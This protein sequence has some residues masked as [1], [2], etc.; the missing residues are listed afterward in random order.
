[1][2]VAG[3]NIG[4]CVPGQRCFD[5]AFTQHSNSVQAEQAGTL[6]ADL[7]KSIENTPL[8]VTVCLGRH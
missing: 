6:T 7:N 2:P 5:T 4:V 8:A 3:D 1:M